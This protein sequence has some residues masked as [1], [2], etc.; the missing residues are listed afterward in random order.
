MPRPYGWIRGEGTVKNQ[1]WGLGS[2]MDTPVIPK[3]GFSG[4][5]DITIGDGT[6]RVS[7]GTCPADPGCTG[8]VAP[9][10]PEYIAS[11][12]DELTRLYD[13]S[14]TYYQHTGSGNEESVAPV[15][16]GQWIKENSTLLIVGGIVGLMLFKR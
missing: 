2:L 8:Y 13:E 1:R 11:L 3:L 7:G 4:L 9:N 15:T 6:F 5:G 12:Q 10:S 16:A 14:L